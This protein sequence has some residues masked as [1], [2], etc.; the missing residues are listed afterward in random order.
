M[1]SLG[2]AL[3]VLLL[4][5]RANV[6]TSIAH[7]ATLW[8]WVIA[9]LI[10]LLVP[11]CTKGVHIFDNSRN[12]RLRIYTRSLVA[13]QVFILSQSLPRWLTNIF[14]IATLRAEDVIWP[15][16][17]QVRQGQIGEH[18]SD[19][20][21]RPVSHRVICSKTASRITFVLALR[22]LEQW[23]DLGEFSK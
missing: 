10:V 5:C 14:F 22:M 20:V 21:P 15:V 7:N 11:L 3:N 8:I 2:C 17:A 6:A 23:E 12:H 18:S 4:G 9:T 13:V 1:L 19:T 16:S